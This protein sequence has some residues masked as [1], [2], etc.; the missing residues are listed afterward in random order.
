MRHALLLL[1]F[2]A[3]PALAQ[4]PPPPPPGSPPGSPPP[5]SSFEQHK[6]MLAARIQARIANEQALLSCVQTA[7]NRAA[8]KACRR[9]VHTPH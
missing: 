7:A 4:M 8:L 2:A 5:S 6:A 1:A 3:A 9:M